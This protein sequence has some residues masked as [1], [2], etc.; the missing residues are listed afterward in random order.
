MGV[1]HRIIL[2]F[3]LYGAHLSFYMVFSQRIFGVYNGPKAYSIMAFGF[4]FSNLIGASA[5]NVLLAI[6][7][8]K[9]IFFYFFGSTL[10]SLIV[11]CL[12]RPKIKKFRETFEEHYDPSKE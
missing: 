4:F 10:V 5:A 3:W 11:F 9:N 2:L 8:Y 1:R 7:G 6:F 12:Y